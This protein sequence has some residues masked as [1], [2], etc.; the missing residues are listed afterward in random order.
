MQFGGLRRRECD[1]MTVGGQAARL[2][3]DERQRIRLVQ[4]TQLALRR[5]LV[6]RIA[7]DAA[8]QEIAMEVGDQ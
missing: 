1:R 7:E 6:G 5:L 4:Q 8:A 3:G 2:F